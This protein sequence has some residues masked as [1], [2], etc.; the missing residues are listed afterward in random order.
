MLLATYAL[1][2]LRIE[3]KRERASIQELQDCLAHAPH[4]DAFDS[5]ALATRSERLSEFAE[6]RHQR[7]LENGLFPALRAAS[8]EAGESLRTLEHLGRVGLRILPRM[9]SVLRPGACLGQQQ[10]GRAC[11]LV[12]AYC[13]N[14]LERLACEE[15]VLLPL[16]ERVLH[17]EVW[18]KVGTEFLMQDAERA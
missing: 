14:L 17:S 8:I 10:I 4:P 12:Q 13:Q 18:F 5:A 7:R 16:A 6:S 11:A 2:T 1:L 15:D 3:Q 9:R